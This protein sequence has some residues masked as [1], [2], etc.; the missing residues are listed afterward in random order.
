MIKIFLGNK[1]DLRTDREV[2]SE[3]IRKKIEETSFPYF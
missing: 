1:S 2:S 3:A